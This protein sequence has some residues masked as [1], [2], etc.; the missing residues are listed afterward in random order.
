MT[1]P[2]RTLERYANLVHRY[3]STLDLVSD[4]GL[5]ALPKH[6]GDAQQYARLVQEQCGPRAVI[7]DVG[8]GAGLPGVVIAA[9]LPEATVHLV[10]RRR[11]R[12]A[13]LELVVANLGLKNAHVFGGDVR[14]LKGVC[15]DAVTAQAV[16]DAATL[17]G[18][19]RHLHRETCWIVSR[20]GEGE[21]V[22][23]SGVWREAGLATSSSAAKSAD[24]AMS[25]F[26]SVADSMAAEAKVIEEPLEGRGSLVAI[27]LPGGSACLP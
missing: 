8:S 11:R 14:D 23:V 18:L 2:T 4:A 26:S 15:A 19:T 1:D 20:R 13:F 17:V 3:H 22:D 27:K 12:A 21:K 25:A 5:V 24:G 16:A 7:V 9:A 10:E 6:I